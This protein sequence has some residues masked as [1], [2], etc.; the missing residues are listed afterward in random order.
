MTSDIRSVLHELRRRLAARYGSRLVSM[1]LYGS[2]ARG[3]P[4]DGSDIDVLVV[5]DGAVDPSVEIARTE[6]DVANVSLAHDVAVVCVFVSQDQFS[7]E[8][9][10]LLL[11]ARRE[12]VA[13]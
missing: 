5:L 13:V 12:G 11:N 7:S 6:L 9:S 10:P 8:Q 1:V 2:Y 4:E 3:E